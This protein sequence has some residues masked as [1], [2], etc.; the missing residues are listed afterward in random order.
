IMGRDLPIRS[1]FECPTIKQL[2]EIV[3][4]KA[5]VI[6]P[7]PLVTIQPHGTKPPFFWVYGGTHNAL[8]RR[9]LGPEQPLYG[10]I[11]PALDGRDTTH[12][13][14]EEMAK[15]YVREIRTVEPKGPYLLGGYC[16][17]GAVCIE[18]AHELRKQGQEV[19]MLFIVDPPRKCVPSSE[20]SL[21][22]RSQNILSREEISRHLNNL[23]HLSFYNKFTYVLDRILGIGILIRKAVNRC[24]NRMKRIVRRLSTIVCKTYFWVGRSLPPKLR[25]VYIKEVQ[26]LALRSYIPRA[27]PGRITVVLSGK[28]LSRRNRDWDLLATEGVEKF[29]IPGSRHKDIVFAPYVDLLAEQL[30]FCLGKAQAGREN[31]S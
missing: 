18:M 13:R 12:K 4:D 7:S 16:F 20:S 19:S 14:I 26:Y 30:S 31:T 3:R 15:D 28:D 27:Y 22:A 8:L 11:P 23:G 2:A 5:Y 9:I 25:I 6:S 24:R 17:G 1:L 10:V 21:G 29:M